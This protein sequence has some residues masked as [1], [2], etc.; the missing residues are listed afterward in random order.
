M[1]YMSQ[2]R[3]RTDIAR[4]AKNDTVLVIG[5]GIGEKHADLSRV[6]EG[7]TMSVLISPALHEG[8]LTYD[9]DGVVEHR[10]D[11]ANYKGCRELSPFVACKDVCWRQR[12]LERRK[13]F[14][15]C[16]CD[17]CNETTDE[18]PNDFWIF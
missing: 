8:A 17:Q 6:Y 3:C 11:E 5:R 1:I 4:Q 14:P 13:C 18:C 7:K 2:G 10:Y 12:L 9:V 15:K 16:E